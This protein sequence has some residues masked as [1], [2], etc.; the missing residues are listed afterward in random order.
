MVDIEEA[1]ET[2]SEQARRRQNE[3]KRLIFFSWIYMILVSAI[4]SFAL[5]NMSNTNSEL[6][7]VLNRRS[8]VLEYLRCHDD[9]EDEKSQ[10]Q[11]EL[12]L[13]FINNRDNPSEATQ[14]NFDEA[15][16]NYDIASKKLLNPNSCPDFPN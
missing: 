11:T 4:F 1:L 7:E 3:I 2:Q 8:P 5:F 13:S 12:L 9:L 16:L 6:S 14:I 10:A 15:V